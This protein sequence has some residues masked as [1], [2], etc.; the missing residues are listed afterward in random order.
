MDYYYDYYGFR[1]YV[2]VAARRARAARELA[3]LRKKGHQTSPIVIEG[4]RIA[5]TFWGEAWCDN[6]ERYSDFANRLPRGRTYVRNGSVVDLQIA[7]GSV[8]ALVSGSAIYDVTVSIAPVS[9]GRWRSICQECSGAIDSLVELLQGR[10]SKGVMTRLCEQQTGL[11]PSPEDIAFTCNCPDWASMCKHVAAVLYG[12]GARLDHQPELLFTL[13]KVNQ[14]ELIAKVG[15]DLSK[16]RRGP[17]GAKVL[18]S[19]D[20]A[21][22]F[23]I[24][25]APAAPPKRARA[26]RA[27]TKLPTGPVTSKPPT[28]GNSKP[29]S[30]AVSA[31]P[32]IRRTPPAEHR[33]GTRSWTPSA[34]RA[35][36]VRMKKYWA[37]RR[38]LMKRP[39]PVPPS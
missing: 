11:F 27:A 32:E 36:S 2:S 6:L 26:G 12:I 17:A 25:V 23:G 30:K 7:S 37:E 33:A 22:M 34:R 35:V 18:A 39:R 20:L 8:T 21:G 19:D 24:E 14:Q 16:T 5:R 4:R 10:F 28:E 3:K 29:S 38:A 15:S 9:R 1:P 31:E 13:R